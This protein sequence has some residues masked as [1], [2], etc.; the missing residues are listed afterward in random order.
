[1]KTITIFVRFS[2]FNTETGSCEVEL[3]KQGDV[4]GSEQE[5]FDICKKKFLHKRTTAVAWDY[6]EGKE[7]ANERTL[8]I[9]YDDGKIVTNYQYFWSR[10]GK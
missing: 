1:M 3:R 8:E 9:T 6:P 7:T 5:A 10:V 4:P 2:R